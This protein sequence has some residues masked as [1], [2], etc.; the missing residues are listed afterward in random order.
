MSKYTGFR[1]KNI[2]ILN[3]GM[4]FSE[5]YPE[6]ELHEFLEKARQDY[7]EM[8]GEDVGYYSDSI[9]MF[10]TIMKTHPEIVHNVA[11]A[12]SK[13]Y[14]SDKYIEYVIQLIPD[15]EF[16][17]GEEIEYLMRLQYGDLNVQQ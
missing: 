13:S 2:A 11:I 8:H 6:S 7:I 1:P 15:G 10:K 16:F 17:I 3:Q 14:G 9:R 12:V 4:F 5:G